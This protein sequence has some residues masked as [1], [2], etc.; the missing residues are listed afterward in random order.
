MRI[1]E[2]NG[3]VMA[4]TC[5]TTLN[6]GVSHKIKYSELVQCTCMYRVFKFYVESITYSK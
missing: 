1:I 6:R 2:I 5:C 3:L 4:R